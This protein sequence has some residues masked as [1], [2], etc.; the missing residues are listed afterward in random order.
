MMSRLLERLREVCRG[1]VQPLG[2]RAA[3]TTGKGPAMALIAALAPGDA[4]AAQESADAVLLSL[5][6][7]EGAE[8]LGQIGASLG[9][10]PWGVSLDEVSEEGLSRLKGMGCDFLVFDAGA[11]PALLREGMGKIVQIAPS[12]ADGL[13]RAI[14]L[15]P[16]DGVLIGMEGEHS[17]SIER[18][19]V[20]QHV[21]SL[22][23][24]PVVA[25]APSGMS[26]EDLEGLWEAGMAGV[27]VEV[28]GSVEEE[29]SRLR[30]AIDSLPS[31]R[32]RKRRVEP[33]VPYARE[34]MIT[35]P[36]EGEE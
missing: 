23:S 36:E 29:L 26:K 4:G 20:C 10:V 6:K 2:F 9:Q 14:E 21:A 27:V 34:G 1:G 16:I 7:L 35:P 25:L 13:V 32:G 28:R 30:Q 22:V 19:M 5:G 11:P 15:L 12:L 8:G 18:L 17:L 31:A 24:K 3:A 33:L